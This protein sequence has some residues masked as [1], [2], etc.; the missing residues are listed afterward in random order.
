MKDIILAGGSGPRL[1]PITMSV[2]KQLL[3]KSNDYGRYLLRM[4][5]QEAQAR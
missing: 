5:G 3:M 2:S 4:L 1:Y